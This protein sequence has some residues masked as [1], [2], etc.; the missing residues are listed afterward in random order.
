M[1]P[2]YPECRRGHQIVI[3][4]M[5]VPTADPFVDPFAH[6]FAHPD[7]QRRF[8]VLRNVEELEAAFANPWEKWILFLHPSQTELVEKEFTGPARASGSAGT[9]KTIVALHRAVSLARRHP[10]ARVLLTTFSET[11]AN[12]LRTRL[13]RLLG[14]E[15]KLGRATGSP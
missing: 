8:R 9:G 13:L 15:P 6:P 11:L 4:D 14:S 10:D 2:R 3:H 1:D 12:A 7:A 5:A